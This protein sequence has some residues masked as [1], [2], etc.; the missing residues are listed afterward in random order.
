M[1]VNNYEQWR[2]DW[3]N[4]FMSMDKSR[5]L[6]KLP[7]LQ[8]ADERLLV[9]Y[10]GQRCA[11]RLADGV[12]EGPPDWD[13]LSLMDEMN[14]FTMLWYSREGAAL[15]GDW[16]P[17]EQLRDARAFGPAFRRGNLAPFA[18]TFD[19][20]AEAL[21]AALLSYGGLPLSTGDVGFQIDVFP[22]IPMRVLFWDGDDEF[23]AQ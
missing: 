9:P 16:L 22:C 20:H 15:T 1:A 17:F 5:L 4:R 19:G 13:E 10:F 12:I 2:T 7:F 14:I 8:I 18:A 21:K 23:P 3:Q 11:V 6:R